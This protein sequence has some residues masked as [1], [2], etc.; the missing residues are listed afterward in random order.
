MPIALVTG[1]GGLIGS[2]AAH[3]GIDASMS[4]DGCMHSLFGVAKAAADLMVQ[5]Y[6][7]YFD[8]PTACFRCGCL[9]GPRHAGARQ[10]GFLSYLMR[11]AV[12]GET[13]TIYGHE[14]KQVRDNLHSRDVLSAAL[15]YYSNPKPAAV[16]NLGGG[17]HSNCSVLEAIALC[18]KITGQPFACELDDRARMGEHRWWISDV[19]AFQADYPGWVVTAD[20][21]AILREIHDSNAELWQPARAA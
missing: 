5:E 15:A 8:M 16:C 14:G 13:Y 2:E 7:R 4:I 18:E 19:A 10:Y 6:G 21:P 12:T 9:T 20:V 11:A 17:R 3:G 1:S